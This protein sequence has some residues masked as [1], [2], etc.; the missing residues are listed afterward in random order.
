MHRL[1][2]VLPR[3]GSFDLFNPAKFNRWLGD[4]RTALEANPTRKWRNH[5]TGLS[6]NAR[7]PGATARPGW[8]AHHRST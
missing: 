8:Q 2:I 6:L 5:K 1:H 4:F 7:S 3:P